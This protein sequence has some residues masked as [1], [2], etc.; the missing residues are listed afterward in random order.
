MSFRLE[1]SIAGLRLRNPIVKAS[2]VLDDKPELLD[3]LLSEACFGA[4]VTKSLTLE[5]REG[6][7]PPIIVAAPGGGVINAVGLAN[8]GIC[9]ARSLVEACRKHS[10]PVIVS[11]APSNP[12]EAFELAAKAEEAGADAIEVNLSCPHVRGL[13]ASIVESPRT[14][15]MIVREASAAAKIPVIAKLGYWDRI[16]DHA[17]KALE[18]GAKA[19]T[20]IN[21]VKAMKIDIYTRRPVLTAVY[22]GLSGPPIRPLAVYTVYVVYRETRAEIMG[23]GGVDSWEAAIELA[24]AGARAVQIATA[25]VLEGPRVVERIVSGVREYLEQNNL[26]WM[27]LVGAAHS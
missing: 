12:H 22:G 3:R 9:A 23:C 1:T 10:T 7:N 20:L 14:T 11:I 6:Y 4:V 16:V 8:P 25:L 26:S 18:A 17:S 21:T 13:G 27:D 19:L 15:Y 2:G 5:P 24:L